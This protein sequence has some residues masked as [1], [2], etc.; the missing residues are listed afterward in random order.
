MSYITKI[1]FT[2]KKLI[3]FLLFLSF[4]SC[5]EDIPN[6]NISNNNE[7]IEFWL[8]DPNKDIKFLK[9]TT[10]IDTG[11]VQ[12]SN[13]ETITINSDGVYQ[14]MDGFGFAL[15]GGSAYHIYNLSAEKKAQLL[16]ELFDSSGTNIGVSYIRLTVGASDLDQYVYSYNDLEPG[17]TD[18]DMNY[19]SL[20]ED[21]KYV[22]PVMKEILQILPHINY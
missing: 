9:Q 21:R 13:Y 2:I 4:Y 22:I 12:N 7:L 6:D 14:T 10:N 11:Y 3:L 18:I 8:T 1:L 5:K 20:E 19:F 15:T 16:T 17:Q